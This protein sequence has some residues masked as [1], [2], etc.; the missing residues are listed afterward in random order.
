MKHLTFLILLVLFTAACSD[1]DDELGGVQIRIKNISSITYDTVQVGE[2]DKLHNNVGPDE[3]S[4]YLEYETAY[5]YSYV[6]INA[7]EDTY[8]LQPIDFVGE[9]PLSL[10]FYTYELNI[11][12]EGTVQLNFVVD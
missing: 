4:G 10:G 7:G 12:E 1:R 6:R 2:E 9:S 8:I 11:S 3:Y 5:A